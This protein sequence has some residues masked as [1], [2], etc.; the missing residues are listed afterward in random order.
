MEHQLL[1]APLGE[2]PLQGGRRYTDPQMR[3][4]LT[5]IFCPRKEK[6]RRGKEKSG[7]LARLFRRLRKR[8]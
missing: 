7:G 5:D 8:P 3:A 1:T 4:L 2:E 6:R